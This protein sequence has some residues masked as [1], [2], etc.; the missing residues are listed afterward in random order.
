MPQLNV[1]LDYF[2]NGVNRTFDRHFGQEIPAQTGHF[3]FV[4]AGHVVAKMWPYVSIDL[5]VNLKQ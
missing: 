4:G 5:L 2:S 1:S 3:M